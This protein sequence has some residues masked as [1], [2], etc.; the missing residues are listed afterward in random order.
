MY[1]SASDLGRPQSQRCL[2]YIIHIVQVLTYFGIMQC[3][4][5]DVTKLCFVFRLTIK[6]LSTVVLEKKRMYVYYVYTT[7]ALTD[8]D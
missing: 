7:S 1:H 3:V 6:V 5:C 8:C 4:C 2:L